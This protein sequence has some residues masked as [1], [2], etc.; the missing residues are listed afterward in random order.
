MNLIVTI[1]IEFMILYLYL[2]KYCLSTKHIY[3]TINV[4]CYINK[5]DYF[6]NSN[7]NHYIKQL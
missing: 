5:Y 4:S 6:V 2:L 7:M 3:S 1:I